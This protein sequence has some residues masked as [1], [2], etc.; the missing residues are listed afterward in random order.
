MEYGPH[1]KTVRAALAYTESTNIYLLGSDFTHND[2]V[3]QF[4]QF[5]KA[6]KA[7][8]SDPSEARR[9]RWVLI[10]AILQ[11][12]ATVSV[13]TP[14]L[15]Y[16]RDVSYHLSPQLRGTPPWRGAPDNASGA[17]HS[18]SYCWTIPNTWMP[19]PGPGT[20]S[21][22]SGTSDDGSVRPALRPNRWTKESDSTT[23][24]YVEWPAQRVAG[25]E[26]HLVIKDFDAYDV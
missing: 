21:P 20:P 17:E 3:H 7:A 13:D 22:L 24:T 11:T 26:G 2:M 25:R 23:A 4:L 10:Y 18:R 8:E 14:D 12:L 5:E 15:H 19:S 6:D 16:V 9:G 1:G